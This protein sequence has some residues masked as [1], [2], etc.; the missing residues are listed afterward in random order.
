MARY[1]GPRLKLSRREGF[2]LGLTSGV[3]ELGAKC[4]MEVPPGGV[5]NNPGRRLSDFGGQLR[6]KQKVRRMY[7]L[8]E[9]QFRNTYKLAARKRG[10]TGLNLLQLLEMRLDNVCYRSGFAK[11]RA[12][13]RQMVS[14]GA[15]L[16]DGKKANIPSMRVSPG[17]MISIA[18]KANNQIRIKES[19]ELC[20]KRPI[21]CEWIKLDAELKKAQILRLPERLDIDEG[22]NESLVV[23]LYSR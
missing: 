6:E 13:A 22:I 21:P 1:T 12:E 14:H 23:E 2:D 8:L 18:P 20:E 10:S 16:I 11:T 15:L 3:K 17:Q 5:S 19:L 7:G 4:R 9:R